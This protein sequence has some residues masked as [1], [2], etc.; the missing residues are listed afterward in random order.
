L[1]ESSKELRL[2]KVALLP[3]GAREPELT[4]ESFTMA[5]EVFLISK[6]DLIDGVE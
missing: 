4:V 1:R 5:Q 2:R 3:T 6:A